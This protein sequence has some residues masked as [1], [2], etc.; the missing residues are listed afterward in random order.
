[1]RKLI[2]L[3]VL[4][5]VLCHSAISQIQMNSTGNVGIGNINIIS[6][7]NIQ[8]QLTEPSASNLLIGNWW[9]ENEGC[10]SIGVH[11][12]YSWL[13]SWHS[14]PLY[15][16]RQGN[17]VIFCNQFPWGDVGIGY[18]ITT[19]SAKLHVNGSIYATGTITSSDIRMK[20]NI[21]K[22]ILN[23]DLSNKIRRLEPI[24]YEWD[25]N[26]EHKDSLSTIDKAF[27]E[28]KQYGF[29]AQE[30]QKIF[31]ELVFKDNSGM[32]GINYQGFIPI[33]F[34]IVDSLQSTVES[35]QSEIR[36]LKKVSGNSRLKSATTTE[37]STLQENITNALY[38]NVPNPFSQNTSI[39]YYLAENVKK[40]MICIYDMNGTQLKCIQL[41]LK[42]YG[43]ITINGNELKAGMYMY[44]LIADGQLIDTKRMV[45]TD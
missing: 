33:L 21:N 22:L 18:N 30:V 39:E 10:I 38:Q 35:L 5:A 42:G 26:T 8:P 11:N 9:S 36:E 4:S 15:I 2:I 27:Y 14:K 7:L 25:I 20:K 19:P 41:H 40:A 24:I 1:M 23:S 17:N 32:L 29:S 28:K 37:T 13:Q 6:R 16:N 44:S 45:L 34:K 12:N 3:V 31:P 43:N